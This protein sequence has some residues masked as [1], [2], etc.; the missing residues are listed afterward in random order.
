M[1]TWH[2]WTAAERSRL[3]EDWLSGFG[4][5]LEQGR[6]QSAAGMLHPDGYWRDLLTFS[7]DFRTLH[8]A[9]VQH[10]LGAEFASNPA[11]GFCL[12]GQPILSAIVDQPVTL[13]FFFRFETALALGRGHA[14]LV[15]RGSGE[16]REAVAFT[17]LTTMLELKAFP[18]CIGRNRPREDVS[19]RGAGTWPS[20]TSGGASGSVE[21]TET[22]PDVLIVGAGQ[23]GVMLAARLGQLGIRTLL[24]ER[25]EHVGDV[26]RR[27]YQSLKLHNELCMNHFPYLPFP[28]NWP[29]YLPKDKV[30]DWLEFYARAMDL[31]VCAG[32]TFLNGTYD[33]ALRRWTVQLRGADGTLRSLRPRHL[34]MAMGVSGLPNVPRLAGS[35]DFSGLILHTSE[36]TDHLDVRGKKAL[37]VGAGTSAHDLAQSFYL[38]G[39]DVTMLQRSSITVV[40][41]EPSANRAY[42]MYRDNDGVRPIDETDMMAAAVPYELLARIQRSLS[43][44]MQETDRELLDKLRKV[45][46][47]LDNGEDDTGFFMKLLRTQSGYYLNVGASELICDGGIKLKSGVGIERLAKKKVILTD[48]SAVDADIVVLATGYEPLQEQVRALLGEEVANRVGPIWGIGEDGEL[49]N[50]YAPTAQEHFFVVGGGF[51]AARYYSRYTAL[52]IKADLEGLLPARSSPLQRGLSAPSMH[53]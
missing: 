30:A 31:R 38:R 29:V 50:M 53:Q 34:V 10:W 51:P 47:L 16:G 28:E 20:G 52:Y 26:W 37:V 39:A 14:R 22:D 17:L 43:R 45:G 42:Q 46:F 19:L 41:L 48:G 49:R 32:T 25:S 11:H 7:W 40:S 8:A 21:C 6:Y 5:A 33:D 9:E 27:R 24:V 18:E 13:E 23:S 4:C 44:W 3:A 2:K 1:S 35:E 36:P 12:E 15:P